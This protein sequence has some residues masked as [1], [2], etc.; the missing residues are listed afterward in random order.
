[1]KQILLFEPDKRVLKEIAV[2]L[3]NKG[4]TVVGVEKGASGI[5]KALAVLPDIILCNADLHDVTGHHVFETL[6]QY[7]LTAT[8]PF[9]L[10]M[11]NAT[12]QHIRDAMNLGVDDCLAKPFDLDELVQ[13]IEI[14]LK[15]QQK[16]TELAHSIIEQQKQYLDVM[17]QTTQD[18]F[19]IVDD[20]GWIIDVN[21]TYCKMSGFSKDE[22][23]QM[24]IKDQD[25]LE[26]DDDAK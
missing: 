19:W 3:Q 9:V 20:K 14:R 15:K 21:D 17:P 18:G 25:A 12:V 13:V 6:Q 4:Y 26:N 7:R 24:T 8:I 5:E 23:L 11:N 2:F 16:A 1:M 10:L 22:I